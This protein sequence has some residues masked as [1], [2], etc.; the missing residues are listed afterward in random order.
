MRPTNAL[1]E[2]LL[3]DVMFPPILCS[4]RPTT[5]NPPRVSV[6]ISSTDLISQDSGIP[7]PARSGI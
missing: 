1:L 6:I 5:L 7:E 4:L 3:L 2:S